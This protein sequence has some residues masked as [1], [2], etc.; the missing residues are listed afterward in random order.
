MTL[1]F[2]GGGA[3]SRQTEM[4]IAY[5][6]IAL[7]GAKHEVPFGRLAGAESLQTLDA[8]YTGWVRRRVESLLVDLRD[9]T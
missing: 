1:S 3:N 9:E 7:G 8:F 2:A 4:F 5:R 6:D